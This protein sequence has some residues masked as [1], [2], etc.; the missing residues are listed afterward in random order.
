MGEASGGISPE[1]SA[2]PG[3]LRHLAA[4]L[5]DGLLLASIYFVLTAILIAFRGGEAFSPAHPGFLDGFGPMAGK[6]LECV[7]GAFRF[8]ASMACLASGSRRC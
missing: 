5:Y 7:P 6:P 8:K 1:A 4:L 3:F 2:K